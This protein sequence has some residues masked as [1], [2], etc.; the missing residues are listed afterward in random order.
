[1]RF[2]VTNREMVTECIT[3]EIIHTSVRVR[4]RGRQRQNPEE[5]EKSKL[6]KRSSENG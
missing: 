4:R 1:M 5:E 3:D 2:G 6:T